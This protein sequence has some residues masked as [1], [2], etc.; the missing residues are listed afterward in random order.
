MLKSKKI[1]IVNEKRANNAYLCN[2]INRAYVD[3]FFDSKLL[4]IGVFG[5]KSNVLQKDVGRI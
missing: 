5:K 4:N 1:A 2:V 3:T